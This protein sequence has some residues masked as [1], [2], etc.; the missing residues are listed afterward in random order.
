MSA[1]LKVISVTVDINDTGVLTQL[2]SVFNNWRLGLG[3]DA[4]SV[5]TKYKKVMQLLY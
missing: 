5:E 3:K 4:P 2:V 1:R